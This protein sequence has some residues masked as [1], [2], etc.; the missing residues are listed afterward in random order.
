MKTKSILLFALLLNVCLLY[1]QSEDPY[2]TESLAGK[3]IDLVDVQTSGGYIKV[4]NAP[5]GEQR[6][7]VYVRSNNWKSKRSDANIKDRLD[8]D[9]NLSIGM[10]GGTLKA[11]AERRVKD[12]WKN[13]LSISFKVYVEGNVDTD[14]STSGG[15]INIS[16]LTGNQK[17]RTSGGSIDV[18]DC[19]GQIDGR[20]SGGSVALDESDGNINLTTSG[21]SINARD[22]EGEMYLSTSGG[23]V[24]LNRLKG[25]IEAKTSGGSITGENINGD[26][27]CRTSGGS[28]N[29]DDLECGIA[30]STSGGSIRIDLVKLGKRV[31]LRNSGGN[32]TVNM[33]LDQGIDL[34]LRGNKV[35]TT[36]LRNFDGEVSDDEIFGTLN[37]GG[38]PV[39]IRA[40]SGRVSINR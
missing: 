37:G 33:P 35:Y 6:V 5:K 25:S 13:G 1:A 29:L 18:L 39:T 22:S 38:I 28:I 36:T 19:H 16:G 20:T 30:A 27:N 10:T 7:E 34:N 24:R 9:Y 4:L 12:S 15:S 40:S 23:S 8:R 17:F 26:L 14:L 3:N 21:G 2:I 11:L 31:D 32:I